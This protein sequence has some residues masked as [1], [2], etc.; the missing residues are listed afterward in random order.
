M[1]TIIISRYFV[2]SFIFSS[3]LHKFCYFFLI[4]YVYVLFML[5]MHLFLYFWLC[6]MLIIVF[7]L[8]TFSIILVCVVII[9]LF[10]PAS[11]F[12]LPKCIYTPE[13]I[14]KQKKFIKI[15]IHVVH[16]ITKLRK[17]SNAKISSPIQCTI[18]EA[19]ASP[20]SLYLPSALSLSY[21]KH[22]NE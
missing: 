15:N 22:T 1:F 4:H 9:I 6:F 3:L 10:L 2:V 14:T 12:T 13:F 18:H 7:F 21:Y 5:Y 11:C 19:S 17:C 20:G 8:S 16:E